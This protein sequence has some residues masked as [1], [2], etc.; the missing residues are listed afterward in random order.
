[1]NIIEIA[2]LS[3]LTWPMKMWRLYGRVYIFVCVRYVE[4]QIGQFVTATIFNDTS[5]GSL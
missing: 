2:V 5:L 3:A 4:I 1:M